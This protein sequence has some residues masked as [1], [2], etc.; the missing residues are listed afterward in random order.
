MA[1]REP[2]TISESRSHAISLHFLTS[3]GHVRS[4]EPRD[5][6]LRR[7]ARLG[8]FASLHRHNILCCKSFCP[9]NGKHSSNLSG[10]NSFPR[11]AWERPART[12]CVRCAE[13]H[14]MQDVMAAKG[15]E[16]SKACVT[17]QSVV[18]RLKASSRS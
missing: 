5:D 11:F 3:R 10:T 17:T 7:H 15:R 6:A 13:T 16:A 8:R 12:P 18:T 9:G 2:L 1:A 4:S 14:V